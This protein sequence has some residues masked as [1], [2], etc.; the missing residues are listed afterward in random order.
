MQS[1]TLPVR[2]AVGN[3]AM[4]EYGD[5]TMADYMRRCSELG[6]KPAEALARIAAD[7]TWAIP[8]NPEYRLRRG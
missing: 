3:L 5:Q 6:D 1:N 8:L 7:W 2:R 4:A